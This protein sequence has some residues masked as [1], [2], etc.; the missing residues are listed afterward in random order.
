MVNPLRSLNP[1]SMVTLPDVMVRPTL[2]RLKISTLVSMSDKRYFEMEAQFNPDE[3]TITKEAIWG[4]KDESGEAAETIPGVNAPRY[5]FSGGKPATFDLNLLFDTTQ[6]TSSSERDVR[7]YT[8]KLFLLTMYNKSN[9]QTPKPPAVQVIWGSVLLFDAVVTKVEVQFTLFYADGTP[10]RA[11]AKVSFLQF[12]SS[13]DQSGPTNPTTRTEV[14]RTHIV[15]AGERLD[16]IAYQEYGHPSHWR[17]IAE[18]N[19]ILDPLDLQPG[20]ILALP[21]L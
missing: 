2:K 17:H 19:Q 4:L 21:P 5:D 14:R 3:F 8:N 12:D 18:A 10:A 11:K 1:L 20:Q 9:K 6:E 16:M 15:Q 7:K 13:D